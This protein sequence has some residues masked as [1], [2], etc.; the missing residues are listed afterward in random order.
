MELDGLLA[1]SLFSLLSKRNLYPKLL[2]APYDQFH[3]YVVFV[4]HI[5]SSF[6]IY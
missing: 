2:L 4:F 5:E 6:I 1:P 3:V